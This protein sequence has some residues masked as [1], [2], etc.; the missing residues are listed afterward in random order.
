MSEV[1]EQIKTKMDHGLD[2]RVRQIKRL[3]AQIEKL[4]VDAVKESI[5][6]LTIILEH[7]RE[8]DDR[9]W[10]VIDTAMDELQNLNEERRY[11]N[12][13]YDYINPWED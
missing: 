12:L 5:D 1:L 3:R 4:Q 2:P 7:V 8:L 13:K 11:E 9:V 10:L 6:A